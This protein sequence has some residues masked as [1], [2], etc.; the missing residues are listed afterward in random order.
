MPEDQIRVYERF[1]KGYSDWHIY[2]AGDYVLGDRYV[3][4]R[5]W[6]I[7]TL[8]GWADPREWRD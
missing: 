5:M 4:V 8:T 2:F 3:A 1:A 7:E 6:K